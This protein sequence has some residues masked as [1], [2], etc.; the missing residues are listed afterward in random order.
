M[1]FFE[2]QHPQQLQADDIL[3][4]IH[5]ADPKLPSNIE[6]G[7]NTIV[8]GGSCSGWEDGPHLL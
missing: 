6:Q 8:S 7:V 1:S 5:F 3:T 4:T 2:L